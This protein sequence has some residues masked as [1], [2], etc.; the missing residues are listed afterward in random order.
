M[1]KN[2]E[3]LNELKLEKENHRKE[4]SRRY[5]LKRGD[6]LKGHANQS[7]IM[8]DLQKCHP[9]A[10]LKNFSSFYSIKLWTLNR[11]IYD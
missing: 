3:K 1:K 9:T 10:D 6:K 4:S 2:D 5:E 11:T 8:S 7:L